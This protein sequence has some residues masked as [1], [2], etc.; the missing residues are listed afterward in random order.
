MKEIN[1]V[2]DLMNDEEL[3]SYVTEDLEDFDD[4][5]V[6]TYAVWAI[7]YDADSCITDTEMYLGEFV[8]PD[9]AVEKAKALTLADIIHLAAEKDDGSEPNEDVAYVTIEVET[10]V[11]DEEEGSMNVGTIFRKDIWLYEEPDD[12]ELIHIKD[13]EYVLDEDGN[14]II[15]CDQFNHLNKN[16]RIKVMY[17]DEDNTPV[18]TYTIKSKTT[19]N[20]FICEFEY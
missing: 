1:T 17:D 8:D 11:D 15:S 14:L 16:D 19:D 6:V 18:L 3:S 20:K 4:T 12:E 13:N 7:G 5:A 9:R 2:R 10:V